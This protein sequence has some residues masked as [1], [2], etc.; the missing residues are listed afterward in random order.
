MTTWRTR[1]TPIGMMV[2]LIALLPLSLNSPRAKASP[3]AQPPP[4]YTP[5]TVPTPTDT[6]IPPT[7]TPTT[8]PA[9]TAAPPTPVTLTLTPIPKKSG[10]GGGGAPAGPSGTPVN[11]GCVK[12]IGKDGVSLSTAPGFYQPHVQIAPVGEIL[13]V[14]QGPVRVDNIQ[15]WLL[16]TATG[17]EGWGNQDNITPDPGPCVAA[18][19]TGAPVDKALPQTGGGVDG[20]FFLAFVL[21]AVVAAVGIARRRLQAQAIATGGDRGPDEIDPKN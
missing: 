7:P 6:P 15:W 17:I 5:T 18:K 8:E 12:S 14:V 10:G 2:I 20:R 19:A 4:T 13:L 9:L 3:L 1:L 21:V 16:R 11:N